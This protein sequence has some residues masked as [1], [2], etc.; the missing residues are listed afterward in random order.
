MSSH[1]HHS[2]RPNGKRLQLMATCLC[3]AIYDDVAIATVEVLEHLG[4]DISF[5]EAQTCCG[6]PAFNG[7]DWPAS[8]KV[9]RHTVKTFADGVGSAGGV[10]GASDAGGPDAAADIPVVVPSG[11]C[12]AMMFHGALLEFENEPDL[13][14]VAALGARTWELTDYIVNG[15]G[16]KTWPGKFEGK[17]AFHRSCHSRGTPTPAAVHTLLDTIE[18]L[19]V[20]PFGEA[21][22]CCGFGGTFSVTFPHISKAMGELKLDHILAEK[23]DYIVSIDMSCLM[24]LSGLAAKGGRPVRVMHIAQLLRDSLRNAGKLAL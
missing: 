1:H 22:Q 12:A 13:P 9:V 15:L 2:P 5:P 23:P 11:S 3:D 16:V 14:A 4:C 8:R 6:Q 18:G 24:S 20:L 17:V 7:G 10:G 19:T 21:E